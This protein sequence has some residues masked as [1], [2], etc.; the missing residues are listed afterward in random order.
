[1]QHLDRCKDCRKSDRTVAVVAV[2]VGQRVAEMC[3]QAAAAFAVQDS[4]S[5]SADTFGFVLEPVPLA[6]DSDSAC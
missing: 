5:C 2:V 1:V 6:E 3:L 4:R